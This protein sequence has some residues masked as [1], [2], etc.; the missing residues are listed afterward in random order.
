[1]LPFTEIR[2]PNQMSKL[3]KRKFLLKRLRTKLAKCYWFNLCLA[4]L[5]EIFSNSYEERLNL[6]GR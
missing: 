6:D 3:M 2:G 1:M 5:Q 4:F